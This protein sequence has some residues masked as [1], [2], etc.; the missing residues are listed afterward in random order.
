M[1]AREDHSL[2]SVASLH[3]NLKAFPFEER[4]QALANWR[5]VVCQQDAQR[6]QRHLHVLLPLAANWLSLFVVSFVI[7]EFLRRRSLKVSDFIDM[8]NPYDFPPCS[9]LRPTPS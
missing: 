6:H 8:S 1:L 2:F 9:G 4:F 7:P 3:D 5:V